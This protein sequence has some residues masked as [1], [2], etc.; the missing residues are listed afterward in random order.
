MIQAK[1]ILR[2]QPFF[3]SCFNLDAQNDGSGF[4]LKPEK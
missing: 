4:K 3:A 1:G 2:R